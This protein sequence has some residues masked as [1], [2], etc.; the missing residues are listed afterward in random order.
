MT[1]EAS[2]AAHRELSDGKGAGY[3]VGFGFARKMEDRGLDGV[4][5]AFAMTDGDRE[6]TIHVVVSGTAQAV[7]AG[8]VPH[9][10]TDAE[11]AAWAQD[12]LYDKAG[13]IARSD[14][15]FARLLA[16]SPITLSTLDIS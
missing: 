7:L 9:I 1:H 10:T 15:R 12:R 8:Q 16:M 11:L 6:A 5:L 2:A 4:R 14:D 13:R 3:D